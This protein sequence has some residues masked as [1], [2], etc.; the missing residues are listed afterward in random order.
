MSVAVIAN[1]YAQNPIV[2]PGMYIADPEAHVW[3]DGRMY[4]Y[5]SR[6]E[7]DAYWCSY[8][9]HVLSSSDLK[10][11]DIV[12]EAFSSKGANDQIDYHDLLLFAPDCAYK[13]GT[14]YLYYCSP[15]RKLAEGV[16]TSTSPFGP[17]IDGK[18]IKGAH[19][20]DPAV[21]IDTDGQAYYLWGQ[22]K[23]KMA[24]LKANMVEIDQKSIIYP[25]DD[26]G[27]RAFHEGSSLRKIGDTYYLVFADES[28]N[29]RPTCLG[30]ATS[31]TPMGSYT[32]RGVII[33]NIGSDPKVWNN[34]GSIEQF[35]GKWYVFYHRPS[36]NSKKFR[37]ACV[38]PIIINPDGTIDEVEMTTQGALGSPIP[39]GNIMQAERACYLSGKLFVKTRRGSDVPEEELANIHHGDYAAYKYLW[40]SKDLKQ[41]RI[42]TSGAQSGSIEVRL[43]HPTGKLIGT[44]NITA[45]QA[46][47]AYRISNCSIQPVEGEHALF[48][49]FNGD[50]ENKL[51]A[52][53]FQFY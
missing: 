35:N 9:H 19:Q 41:F 8:S 13:D 45:T 6:D 10:T 12:T 48:L 51:Q 36:N 43:G 33:D 52:D 22:G 17:F 7:S 2:P 39:A 3:N 5:G 40:F 44:C 27:N 21:F 42:K 37:K 47:T 18:Q 46:G 16:A 15:G 4:V 50:A 11:W 53:W 38:E 49:I 30:Y 24:K 31:K 34:H 1:S 32:Y 28:R 26:A 20:I 23:P 25:L 29:R 14:Y